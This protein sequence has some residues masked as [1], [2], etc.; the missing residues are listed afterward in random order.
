MS[1]NENVENVITYAENKP[2]KRNSEEA[3]LQIILNLLEN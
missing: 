1:V 2:E 3:D